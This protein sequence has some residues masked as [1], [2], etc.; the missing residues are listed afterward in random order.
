MNSWASRS[1]GGASWP[2]RLVEDYRSARRR[3]DA[4]SLERYCSERAMDSSPEAIAALAVLIKED[5]RQRF[6]RGERP[7]VVDYLDRFPVLR[8]RQSHN[9]M[10]S[11][12]YEE[13]CLREE[14]GERPDPE[15]FCQ[16]YEPW[17]DSLVSQ[18]RYH[19]AFSQL[20]SMPHKPMH[21]PEPGELFRQFRLCSELGRGGVAR[22]YLAR[23]DNLGGRKFVLKLSPDHGDEPSIQGQLDH[24]HIVAVTHV[25]HEPET[26]LRG[27]FMP[28]WPGLPLNQVIDRIDP[29]RTR[30]RSASALW[31]SLGAPAEEEQRIEDAGR[32]TW[33]D[34]PRRGS[35]ADAVAWVGLK[36][37]EALAHAHGRG[38]IHRDIKPANILLTRRGGPL[39]LDFNLAHASSHA[40]EADAANRGGTLPYMAPE[41]LRAFLDPD[42][43]DQVGST[44]DLYSL[45]LVL[46]EL[47]V[48]DGPPKLP[49]GLSAARAVAELLDLR[50]ETPPPPVRQIQPTLPASLDAI[51]SRCVAPNPRDRYSSAEMLAEDFRRFLSRQ[52]RQ[53]AP[54][55]ERL[56]CWLRRNCAALTLALLA[57]VILAVTLSGGVAVGT[58]RA[59]RIAAPG[60]LEDLGAKSASELARI[61][62]SMSELGE[63]S[64]KSP[65][66]LVSYGLIW[67]S[68]GL[69]RDAA[70]FFEK[71][72]YQDEN[73]LATLPPETIRVLKATRKQVGELT[74]LPPDELGRLGKILF[75]D[76]KKQYEDALLHFDL[77]LEKS[78]KSVS[79]WHS[80]GTTLWKLKRFA[81][82]EASY[83][84]ALGLESCTE[85]QRIAMSIELARVYN[86]WADRFFMAAI[87][88]YDVDRE[89]HA[90]DSQRLALQADQRYRMAIEQLTALQ[91]EA[92]EPSQEIE[93]QYARA[94]MGRG[95]VASLDHDYWSSVAHFRHAKDRATRALSRPGEFQT[96]LEAL[97]SMLNDRLAQDQARLDTHHELN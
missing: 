20:A 97:H 5:L 8:E 25:E 60:S 45:G 89:H 78:P 86:A 15:S 62:S 16:R 85:D 13:F 56:A 51:L 96:E 32:P 75:E 33:S 37:A 3:G 23:N 91:T 17:R 10:I 59:P 1:V 81:E 48:G 76:R 93:S 29:A 82:S 30:P 36:L 70:I 31:N 46:R 43:W 49:E 47:L 87:S 95:A 44:A 64:S 65:Q 39:L 7:A 2:S 53:Q 92:D 61:K 88:A 42:A 35:H 72:L 9:R 90:G 84:H 12:A 22:V 14:H 28:Y 80:R 4:P 74:S 63:I 41:Q 18:L 50:S 26:G 27:L 40:E 55:S 71:A 24:P 58:L 19:D 69:P 38:I 21:F 67:A 73:L 94:L 54:R 77:A 11:L 57:V 79:L 83:R 52:P 66:V 34:Y 68:K 6:T